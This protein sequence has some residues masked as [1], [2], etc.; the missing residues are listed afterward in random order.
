MELRQLSTF[1]TIAHTLSFSRAAASLNY[2]QS[3]VSAQI[4]GLE[5][6]LGVA[7]FDRLGRAELGAG[8]LQLA[9]ICPRLEVIPPIRGFV[10]PVDRRGVMHLDRRFF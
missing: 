4:Q 10:V 2:A 8:G 1:R 9:H 7:L 3:T 6:E 5:E